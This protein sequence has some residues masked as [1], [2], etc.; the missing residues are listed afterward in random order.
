MRYLARYLKRGQLIENDE[1]ILLLPFL[2]KIHCNHR[3]Q[4]LQSSINNLTLFY[5]FFLGLVCQCKLKRCFQ[6]STF[7]AQ[8]TRAVNKKKTAV[9]FDCS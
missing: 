6:I 4:I 1:L 2:K 9:P 5:G 7:K 3:F 8:S